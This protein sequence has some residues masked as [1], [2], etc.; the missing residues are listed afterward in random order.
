MTVNTVVTVTS[1][2]CPEWPVSKNI[3]FLFFPQLSQ[4]KIL[5]IMNMVKNK[6]VSIEGALYLAQK[7]VYAEKVRPLLWSIFQFKDIQMHEH[8]LESLGEH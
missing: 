1:T 8:V 5:K 2:L 6:E 4:E 7:E 3:W